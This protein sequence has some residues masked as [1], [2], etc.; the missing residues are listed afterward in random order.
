MKIRY[1]SIALIISTFTVEIITPLI[2]IAQLTPQS[3]NNQQ[4]PEFYN[5][6]G[7]DKYRSGDAGATLF[8]DRERVL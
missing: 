5:E 4:K 1:L 8:S 3:A 7:M 2:A 6:R